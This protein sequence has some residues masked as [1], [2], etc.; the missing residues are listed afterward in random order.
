MYTIFVLITDI[1][2]NSD[3]KHGFL[4]VLAAALAAFF[5]SSCGSKTYKNITYLQDAQKD[6]V[7]AMKSEIGILVQPKDMISIV[8]SS[9]NPELSAMFNLTNVSY[10]AGAETSTTGSYNRILGYSVDSEGFID[11]PIVGKINVAGL[12]RWQVADRVKEE[13]VSRNLLKD[14]V[15]SVEFLNFKISV[16]GEVSHPGTYTITGDKITLL[17]ALSLAGD[18]TIFGR[19]DRVSVV[20]ELNGQRNI[21]VVDIRSVDMFNSPAYYLQQNDVVFVEPNKVRAGQSTINENSLKS[22]SF[23]VSMGSF[24]V[25]IANLVIVVSN[26]RNNNSKDKN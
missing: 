15:V 14:P 11:F 23:W 6:T 25:T 22:A 5:L 24:A 7:M 17:E 2:I 1:Q 8:V 20:R 10:Q 19:R 13:L 9:R 18:L 16:M 3:M 4:P 21:F 12:T 26:N